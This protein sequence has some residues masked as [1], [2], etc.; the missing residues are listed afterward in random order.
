MFANDCGWF[1][2]T[3]DTLHVSFKRSW[4]K[5]TKQRLRSKHLSDWDVLR[6]RFDDVA[7]EIRSIA[8][9][10]H[11]H[12]YIVLSSQSCVFWDQGKKRTTVKPSRG[13]LAESSVESLPKK[14]VFISLAD[15]LLMK[16]VTASED[17]KC[18]HLKKEN[19]SNNIKK[20]KQHND[21]WMIRLK[22]INKGTLIGPLSKA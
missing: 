2:V 8:F 19:I 6:R 21:E 20:T 7:A 3:K 22:K 4:T 14:R 11:P 9:E 16:H 18:I 15:E 1:E 10:K 5:D 13:C 17:N 12:M